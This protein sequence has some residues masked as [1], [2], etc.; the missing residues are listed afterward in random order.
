MCPK[1]FECHVSVTENVFCTPS[2]KA[3]WIHLLTHLP[4]C[5]TIYWVKY[6]RLNCPVSAQSVNGCGKADCAARV[7]SEVLWTF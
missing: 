7:A 2:C 3:V 6:E 5:L 4:G 1:S